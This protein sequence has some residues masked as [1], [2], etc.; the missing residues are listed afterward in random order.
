MNSPGTPEAQ[1]IRVDQ[2]NRHVS[3]KADPIRNSNRN[4]RPVMGLSPS[5]HSA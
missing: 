1:A 5:S 3:Q 4:F 2:L